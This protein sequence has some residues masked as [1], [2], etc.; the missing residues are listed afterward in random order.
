MLQNSIVENR[1][2]HAQLFVGKAGYGTFPLALAYAT[3]ILGAKEGAAL[4]KIENLNHV[5]LHFSFPTYSIDGKALSR[6][7]SKE[8]R[9]MLLE[10]PY[11]SYEDWV[12]RL[13]SERKQLLLSVHE[14]EAVIEQFTLKSYEGGYKILILSKIEKMNREAANKFLKFL[15]EPPEKTLILLTAENID[16]VLPTILSRCQIVQVPR[17][18]PEALAQALEVDYKLAP[19]PAQAIAF[20]AQGDWNLAMQ[21]AENN[22]STTEF[23]AFFIRWVRNAFQAKKKPQVLQDIIAWAQEISG[24]SRDKQK[25]FLDY[26]AEI[27][28]LA[29]LQNY[30]VD[31]LVYR[32]LSLH[33]FKWEGFAQFIHGA[34][35][36]S[37]L[38]EITKAGLHVVRNG[39]AKIIWTDMGIKLTRYIHRA[40]D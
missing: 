28:R 31:N 30:Q 38:E 7:F 34:N 11:A 19:E 32:Q 33:N 20:Q 25:R 23:E 18:S 39:N 8:R 40:A 21:L 4:H 1:I 22:Q 9:A 13:D 26:C 29:L 6:N 3:Q 12:A 2:S 14:I 27:F 37:I 17:I 24:W 16:Y 5:D 15:E 10:N 35:I 36:E